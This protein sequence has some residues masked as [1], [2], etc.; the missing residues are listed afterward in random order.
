[1]PVPLPHRGGVLSSPRH[2][3]LTPRRETVIITITQRRSRTPS[4]PSSFGTWNRLAP[5]WLMRCRTGISP[6]AITS[7]RRTGR[8]K[9]LQAPSRSC[10]LLSAQITQGEVAR[11]RHDR[12]RHDS[13]CRDPRAAASRRMMTRRATWRHAQ[14]L[15][16]ARQLGSTAVNSAPVDCEYLFWS[17]ARMNPSSG[18]R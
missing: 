18:R 3:S 17:P 6:P 9:Q 7:Y 16:A 1:M 2:V 5:P 4:S 10:G 12:R 15:V 13:K 8:V 14:T 11:S